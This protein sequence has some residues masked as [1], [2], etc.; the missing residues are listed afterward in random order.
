MK[1]AVSI[2]DD[3]FEGA[4]RLARR[5]AGALVEALVI[6]GGENDCFRARDVAVQMPFAIYITRPFMR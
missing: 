4:E 6:G 5:M 2:P 3:V 1:T